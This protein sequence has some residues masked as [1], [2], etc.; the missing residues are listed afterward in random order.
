MT[1]TTMD[2]Q[3]G[4]LML[5]EEQ[6]RLAAVNAA[7]PPEGAVCGSNAV[8]DEACRQF[9]AYFEGKLRRLDLPF[10]CH[11]TPFQERVWEALRQIPYGETRTYGEIARQIGHP[12]AA[13][14]VGLAAH[15]NPLMLI[16]P[17]HLSLIHI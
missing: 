2:T 17:C 15:R 12:R 5:C 1:Y 3:A 8:L 11:G 9:E 14:A 16:I 10:A 6:G 4:Q 13:R 7:R